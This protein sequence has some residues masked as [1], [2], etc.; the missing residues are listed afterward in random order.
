MFQN[1]LALD[2]REQERTWAQDAATASLSSE[3][4][5]QWNTNLCTDRLYFGLGYELVSW[6]FKD[7]IPT[8]QVVGRVKEVTLAK[9]ALIYLLEGENFSLQVSHV[10]VRIPQ[11]NFFVWVPYF[12]EIR[13]RPTQDGGTYLSMSLCVSQPSNPTKVRIPG[14]QYLNTRQRFKRE[15]NPETAK[16]NF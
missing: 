16:T 8:A 12:N 4:I 9:D 3:D 14:H 7:G 11:T 2:K 5:L 10:P 15:W 1:Q 6:S 13:C